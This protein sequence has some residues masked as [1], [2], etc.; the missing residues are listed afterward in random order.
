[1]KAIVV[2]YTSHWHIIENN[3]ISAICFFGFY[4]AFSRHCLNCENTLYVNDMVS[5]FWQAAGQA[6]WMHATVSRPY[7]GY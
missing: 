1:M 7:F 4:S 5:I 2:A 3:L 6:V